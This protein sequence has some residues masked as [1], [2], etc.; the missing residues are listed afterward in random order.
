M[1]IGGYVLEDKS[2]RHK[3]E[4][5]LEHFIERIKLDKNILAIFVAGSVTNGIVWEHSDIDMFIITNEQTVQQN[6]LAIQENDINIFASIMT[7]NEFRQISQQFVQG[8]FWHHI[9][10]TGKLVYVTDQGIADFNR[11]LEWVAERDKET[12]ILVR[13]E[14]LI[15]TLFKAQKTLFVEEDIVKSFNWIIMALQELARILILRAGQIPGRDVLSQVKH[16]DGILVTGV[17]QSFKEGYNKANLVEAI[18]II[19]EFLESNKNTLFKPLFEY[20]EEAAGERRQSEIDDYFKRAL[21]NI[22][23]FTL[24]E[25]VEWLSHKGDLVR[26][27]SPK[28]ITAKSRV[29]VDEITVYYVGG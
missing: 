6:F 23:F 2:I 16:L 24:A 11:D 10:S 21:G 25:S 15:V 1:Q 20:L 3:F 8:S 17:I 14:Q 26:S 28:R 27:V 18:N 22:P 29:T 9:L 5:A 19:E 12:Q 7:R 13:T 4:L